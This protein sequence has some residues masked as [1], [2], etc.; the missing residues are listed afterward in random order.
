VHRHHLAVRRD[1]VCVE[2]LPSW[3]FVEMQS[4]VPGHEVPATSAS[5]SRSGLVAPHV[6]PTES[7]IFAAFKYAA[8]IAALPSSNCAIVGAAISS[9]R[10]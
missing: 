4:V 9:R 8:A 7:G 1:A 2:Q 5:L 6:P 3:W 10:T